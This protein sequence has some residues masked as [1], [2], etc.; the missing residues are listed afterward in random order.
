MTV[1][2]GQ[3][4]RG[5]QWS[6]AHVSQLFY[7]TLTYCYDYHYSKARS[8]RNR[9]G[10]HM[11]ALGKG[12]KE[13]TM[14]GCGMAVNHSDH[15]LT[16]PGGLILQTIGLS[17]LSLYNSGEIS[18]EMTWSV[19]VDVDVDVR[20]GESWRGGMRVTKQHVI[21]PRMSPCS[22]L[23]SCSPIWIVWRITKSP[24]SRDSR[25]VVWIICGG[26][27]QWWRH[28]T[29]ARWYAPMPARIAYS[30]CLDQSVGF[31]PNYISRTARQP[32]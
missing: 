17:R 15:W 8:P 1:S 9:N 19:D 24:R 22:C 12:E 20:G 10:K 32:G 7:S 14:Q 2:R 29:G 18:W 31:E 21:P 30:P 13:A 3:K 4:C 16:Q 26:G 11:H 5:Y 6:E 27:C 23:R 25:S 28:S